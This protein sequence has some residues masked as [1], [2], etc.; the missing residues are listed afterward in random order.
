MTPEGRDTAGQ[1]LGNVGISRARD[2]FAVPAPIKRIFD[3]FPLVTYSPDDLPQR[4]ASNRTGNRLLVF[5][6]A[7]GAKSHKPSFNPQC[8]KW[9]VCEDSALRLLY[10]IASDPNGFVRIGI[11]KICRHRV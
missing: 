8:L 4:G 10:I 6:D 9:Q 2:Y 11:L 3:Q 7:A 1:A 5:T